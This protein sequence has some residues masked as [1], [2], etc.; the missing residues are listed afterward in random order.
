MVRPVLRG[1]ERARS[2]TGTGVARCRWR[3]AS[4]SSGVED[5]SA[6]REREAIAGRRPFARPVMTRGRNHPGGD[7]TPVERPNAR[8][9]PPWRHPPQTTRRARGASHGAHTKACHTEAGRACLPAGSLARAQRA[10]TP[11][12]GHCLLPHGGRTRRPRLRGPRRR[13]G[14]GAPR[15]GAHGP[16]AACRRGRGDVCGRVVRASRRRR[17]FSCGR[18]GSPS[19]TSRAKRFG[20]GPTRSLGSGN[21]SVPLPSPRRAAARLRGRRQARLSRNGARSTDCSR[22][23]A[24]PRRPRAGAHRPD[25]VATRPKASPPGRT[26]F[27]NGGGPGRYC[28]GVRK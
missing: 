9:L 26:G 4:R 15:C 1:V 28:P 25:S 16:R 6:R 11:R 7:R 5:S 3:R 23:R 20:R 22:R 18:F 14:G 24:P 13:V 8:V 2:Q 12:H 19:T 27:A 17:A 10:A 21:G